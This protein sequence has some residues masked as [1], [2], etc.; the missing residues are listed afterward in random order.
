MKKYLGSSAVVLGMFAAALVAC[1]D[2]GAS[3]QT[4]QTKSAITARG[5]KSAGCAGA[6]VFDITSNNVINYVAL[7]NSSFSDLNASLYALDKDNQEQL[8]SSSQNSNQIDQAFTSM[9]DQVSNFTSA[10]QRAE[11]LAAQQASS[12]NATRS[13][14][15]LDQSDVA[16]TYNTAASSRDVSHSDY[17]NTRASGFNNVSSSRDVNSRANSSNEASAWNSADAR[18]A[19]AAAAGQTNLA[20]SARNNGASSSA[21]NAANA[22]AQNSAFNSGSAFSAVAADNG[23]KG[24]GWGKGGFGFN[25]LSNLSNFSNNVFNDVRSS[26]YRNQ[27][28]DLNNS[29]YANLYDNQFAKTFSNAR[30]HSDSLVQSANNASSAQNIHQDTNTQNAYDRADTISHETASHDAVATANSATT[31]NDLSRRMEASQFDAV[32]SKSYLDNLTQADTSA[33]NQ[34]KNSASSKQM[35]Q[36]YTALDN[37]SQFNSNHLV[38]KL[39]VTSNSQ[40]A[41]VRVFTGNNSN[42]VASNQD[43]NQVFAGCGVSA[44]VV[45]VKGIPLNAAPAAEQ[46]EAAQLGDRVAKPEE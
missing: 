10:S 25:D 31:R 29:Q 16:S 39:N 42:N 4:E 17:S 12:S 46:A 22:A 27:R 36:R 19:A 13:V 45:P 37:L 23:G 3:T 38:L 30:Q 32:D 24:V 43:F 28:S 9:L 35:A 21:S 18:Q 1:G 7:D 8:V 20:N 2:E 44:D 33:A 15:T 5:F 26:Q 6:G 41:I 34:A 14:T 11:Q 40:S